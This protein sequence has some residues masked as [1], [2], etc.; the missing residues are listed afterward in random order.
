MVKNIDN[1]FDKE[2]KLIHQI[3]LSVQLYADRVFHSIHNIYNLLQSMVTI[4]NAR[5]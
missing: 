3:F 4:S 5:P 2:M 1:S